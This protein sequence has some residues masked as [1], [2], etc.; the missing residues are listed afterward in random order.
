MISGTPSSFSAA[1]HHACSSHFGSESCITITAS[2]PL[3]EL[4]KAH[5]K[6]HLGRFLVC[7]FESRVARR[8][9]RGS[10]CGRAIVSSLD[11]NGAAVAPVGGGA[12]EQGVANT[13]AY[14]YHHFLTVSG[15]MRWNSYDHVDKNWLP[16]K[17]KPHVCIQLK[18]F[19]EIHLDI[20]LILFQ[21]HS[22]AATFIA[23][24]NPGTHF[25]FSRGR[26]TVTNWGWHWDA[27]EVSSTCARFSYCWPN[28]EGGLYRAVHCSGA[29]GIKYKNFP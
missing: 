12:D 4:I 28:T 23:L 14:I 24:W 11:D 17:I 21:F 1:I 26:L 6:C 3:P 16:N 2:S 20:E 22:T 5:Q 29:S 7:N 27:F 19:D 8:W 25:F 15:G 9:A 13:N 18:A 10:C